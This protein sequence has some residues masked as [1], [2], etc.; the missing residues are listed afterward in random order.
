MIFLHAVVLDIPMINFL[1]NTGP[2]TLTDENGLTTQYGI[3]SHCIIDD[4]EGSIFVRVAEP[5]ILNWIGN[6]IRN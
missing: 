2:L 1:R 5:S 6:Q 4:D 3:V